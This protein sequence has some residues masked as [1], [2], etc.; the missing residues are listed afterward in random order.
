[1]FTR[2]GIWNSNTETKSANKHN[3]PMFSLLHVH[4]FQGQTISFEKEINT[5]LPIQCMAF[6]LRNLESRAAFYYQVKLG[7]THSWPFLKHNSMVCA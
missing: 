3:T 2:P 4:M 6:L 1:M 5:F 7:Y